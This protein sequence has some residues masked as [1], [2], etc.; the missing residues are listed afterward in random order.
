MKPRSGRRFAEE[1][2]KEGGERRGELFGTWIAAAR[3]VRRPAEDQ[4]FL[5][6]PRSADRAGWRIRRH[7]GQ[8]R[9]AIPPFFSPSGVQLG[10]GLGE[11]SHADVG[12]S[13]GFSGRT[14][15]QTG[16]DV[17]DGEFTARD[18]SPYTAASAVTSRSLRSLAPVLHPGFRSLPIT[19]GR[20]CGAGENGRNKPS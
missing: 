3:R 18:S 16:S 20:V 19:R 8:G 14:S 4:G 17:A 6:N 12:R 2:R 1:K 5:Y 7:G 9:P 13:L 11:R 10:K 15:L